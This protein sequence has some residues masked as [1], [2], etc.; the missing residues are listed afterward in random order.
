MLL[1]L[2]RWLIVNWLSVS[3]LWTPVSVCLNYVVFYLFED[4]L[5]AFF[6]TV[7]ASIG[8]YG[9]DHHETLKHFLFFSFFVWFDCCW[10]VATVVNGD[11]GRWSS[12]W[13]FVGCW[14]RTSRSPLGSLILLCL[15]VWWRWWWCCLVL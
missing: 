8:Y 11:D 15:Q 13:M 2:F 10:L 3:L 6:K 7:A 1:L 12:V 5:Q 4:I 14:H 9:V